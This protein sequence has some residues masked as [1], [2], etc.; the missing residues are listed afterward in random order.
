MLIKKK[1]KKDIS[2]LVNKIYYNAKVSDIHVKYFTTSNYNKFRKEMLDAKIKEKGLLV[3]SDISNL[4]KN[5]DL[6]TKLTT[7]TTNAESDKIVKLQ[8]FDSSYFCGKSHFEDNGTQNHL[9]F[10][11]SC[12]CFIKIGNSSRT[13]TWKPK[14][15]S[16][17]IIKPSSTSNNS[18]A[19]A[20]NY[21]NV[22][23]RLKF[24]GSCLKQD[25]LTFIH[26][27]MLNIYIVY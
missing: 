8:A 27:Q 19:Q 24:D 2:D 14:K 5:F 10:K 21:M 25:K 22:K 9:A 17:E 7:Q 13:S 26:K 4:V 12:R 3:K 11:P 16:D 6:Y 20:L 18:L 15:L 1:K 23:I